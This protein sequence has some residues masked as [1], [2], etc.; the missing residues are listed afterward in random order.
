MVV[1]EILRVYF[2][3]KLV[4]DDREPIALFPLPGFEDDL[5]G[6]YPPKM[7][8]WNQLVLVSY[9]SFSFLHLL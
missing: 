3:E 4:D 1:A 9:A 6:L 5:F 2:S 7:E 8:F